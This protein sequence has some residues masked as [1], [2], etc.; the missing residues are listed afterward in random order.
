MHGQPA[1]HEQERLCILGLISCQSLCDSWPVFVGEDT[2][3]SL[4]IDLPFLGL[5]T[6]FERPSLTAAI[7][8]DDVLGNRK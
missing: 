3:F 4:S 1:A 5:I 7:I 8:V 2:I 6:I